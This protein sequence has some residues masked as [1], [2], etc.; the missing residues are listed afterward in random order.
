[1]ILRDERR[2]AGRSVDPTPSGLGQVTFSPALILGNWTLA[3]P[4]NIEGDW[5]CVDELR[6]GL[7]QQI[8][9]QRQYEHYVSPLLTFVVKF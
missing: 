8:D 4:Q 1:M 7:F 5:A 9:G 3:S 6:S 2:G